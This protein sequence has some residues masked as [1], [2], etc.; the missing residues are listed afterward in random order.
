ML[1]VFVRNVILAFAV[2]SYADCLLSVDM[3]N[4]VRLI[5]I[6]AECLYAECHTAEYCYSEC[7]YTECHVTIFA[8]VSVTTAK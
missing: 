1:N 5:V 8:S 7:L 4:K 2:C 6:Y 3:Q